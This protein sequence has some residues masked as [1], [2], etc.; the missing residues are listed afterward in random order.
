VRVSDIQTGIVLAYTDG[1]EH[2]ER[3]EPDPEVA[4][5]SGEERLHQQRRIARRAQRMANGKD[6][7]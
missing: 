3:P 5:S 6:G 1:R 4:G 2:R 7:Q